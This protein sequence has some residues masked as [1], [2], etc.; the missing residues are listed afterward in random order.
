M[1]PA[2]TLAFLHLHRIKR[3]HAMWYIIAQFV[4]AAL[5][6]WL[7]RILAGHFISS[8]EVNYV[9]TKPGMYGVGAAFLAEFVMAFIMFYT[10][11][12]ISNSKWAAWTGCVAAT[13]V[14][15]FISIEGPLSGMSINPARTTASAIHAWQWDGWWLYFLAP[16]GG[17]WLAATFFRKNFM[18]QHEGDCSKINVQ[19]SDDCRVSVTYEVLFP[20]AA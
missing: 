19:F 16:I 1:N 17:M 20:P 4:G 6:I 14:F 13:L 7:I 12:L 8:P 3:V 9:V 2:V 11:L 18:R 15:L 10:V 5:A